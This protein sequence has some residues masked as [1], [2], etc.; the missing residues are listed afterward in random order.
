MKT[1]TNM[2]N[3]LND[4]K[5]AIHEGTPLLKF[6]DHE[7]HDCLKEAVLSRD[8]LLVEC[9][10]ALRD[11][12]DHLMVDPNQFFY[13][14]PKQ[15]ILDIALNG[16]ISYHQDEYN[17]PSTHSDF[18]IVC[19][20]RQYGAKRLARKEEEIKHAAQ[21]L[22]MAYK[23]YRS[24]Q[25]VLRKEWTN[26]GAFINDAISDLYHIVPGFFAHF[27][28]VRLVGFNGNDE[29]KW[30]NSFVSPNYER[31]SY[32][33]N[34]KVRRAIN[35]PN[36]NYHLINSSIVARDKVK[37]FN[38]AELQFLD[39]PKL[40]NTNPYP[41]M[42]A[43]QNSPANSEKLDLYPSLY[44]MLR[45]LYPLES[46][47]I[48]H[49][50]PVALLNIKDQ[51]SFKKIYRK[52][53][54]HL[55]YKF[56]VDVLNHMP[57]ITHDRFMHK[58]I[59]KM[60]QALEWIAFYDNLELHYNRIV[61]LYIYI[62]S[63]ARVAICYQ[64]PYSLNDYRAA[65]DFIQSSRLGMENVSLHHYP[66]KSGM[67]S[68]L[69]AFI[70]ERQQSTNSHVTVTSVADPIHACQFFHHLYFEADNLFS[71]FQLLHPSSPQNSDISPEIFIAGLTSEH[72]FENFENS[73]N[74]RSSLASIKKA[75]SRLNSNQ[76]VTLIIDQ[77]ISFSE[78]KD[79]VIQ[80]IRRLSDEI[81]NG[82]INILMCKSL[83]KYSSL[84]TSGIKLGNI[85]MLNNG[86][87]KFNFIKQYLENAGENNVRESFDEV[88]IAT[89]FLKKLFQ[90]E[91]YFI[92]QASE[93]AR[94]FKEH[95]YANDPNVFTSGP[96]VHL[97]NHQYE[98]NFPQVVNFGFLNTST[99]QW[100]PRICMGLEAEKKKSRTKYLG[101]GQFKIPSRYNFF[102]PRKSARNVSD[103]NHNFDDSFASLTPLQSS[104]N[105]PV[106]KLI[107]SPGA[108]KG[109]LDEL[110]SSVG[111]YERN[112]VAIIQDAVELL[113]PKKDDRHTPNGLSPKST[114]FMDSPLPGGNEINIQPTALSYILEEVLPTRSNTI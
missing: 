26:C 57:M 49:A 106:Q 96:F 34:N 114:H 60:I 75:C 37:V 7:L 43:I 107:L 1:Y 113:T 17:Q 30:F 99:V 12:T 84:G 98:F 73:Q 72:Q 15:S 65:L 79:P 95:C 92:E 40:E 80:F 29:L 82:K 22:Q 77:S 68:L 70:A 64:A 56:L 5:Q 51:P 8:A 14:T 3:T 54:E 97:H 100:V 38:N 78:E 39:L 27:L 91:Y 104:Q 108:S 62:M 20:L 4:F 103:S 9:L 48:E 31:L 36:E 45:L 53:S 18:H 16:H 13:G 101:S 109:S 25:V 86:D 111:V 2:G 11:P 58:I 83:Q 55:I 35:I 59:E 110:I 28:G 24:F 19:I 85:T 52:Q 63:L 87:N 46:Q 32:P 81:K 50:E 10:L 44:Q 61:Q 93:N 21:T 41:R 69:T 112:E 67:D 47:T 6:S 23:R 71:S 33:V 94:L 90:D 105:S 102:L 89:F 66:V 88:Q 42:Y 74:F 76:Y